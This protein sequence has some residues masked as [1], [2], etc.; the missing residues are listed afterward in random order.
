MFSLCVILPRLCIISDDPSRK[1]V[2][3]EVIEKS[4]FWIM[5]WPK[6]HFKYN[7]VY[8]GGL[9]SSLHELYNFILKTFL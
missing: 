3:L 8:L 2:S 5:V 9:L 6:L 1:A 4:K 7:I